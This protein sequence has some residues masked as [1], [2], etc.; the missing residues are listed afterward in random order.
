MKDIFER[1][2]IMHEQLRRKISVVGK[3]PITSDDDL[4]LAYTPGGRTPVRIYC[5]WSV[6]GS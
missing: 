4:S 1:S 2:L 6:Q 5:E 3:M